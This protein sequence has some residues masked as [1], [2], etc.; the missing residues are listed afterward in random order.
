MSERWVAV[1]DWRTNMCGETVTLCRGDVCTTASVKDVSCCDRWEASHAVLEDLGIPHAS[2]PSTCSG[3]GEARV[4]IYRGTTDG[5][6]DT[7]EGSFNGSYCAEPGLPCGGNM[8]CLADCPYTSTC[9]FAE[10]TWGRCRD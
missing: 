9:D 6:D 10:G 8:P 7:S 3:Y 4:K 1:P 2:N 5:T